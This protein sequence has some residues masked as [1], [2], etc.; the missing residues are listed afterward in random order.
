MRWPSES[1]LT[2]TVQST[3]TVA[4]GD[5]FFFSPASGFLTLPAPAPPAAAVLVAVVLPPPAPPRLRRAFRGL[6]LPREDLATAEEL[7]VV[8]LL[9]KPGPCMV[10]VPVSAVLRTHI[11]SMFEK[12][13]GQ[14][15]YYISG[16]FE[17]CSSRGRAHGPVQSR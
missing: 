14:W 3:S 5:F 2:F 13:G 9:F 17:K 1:S 12:A 15:R 11:A 6:C 10:G 7:L 4:P 16:V 8:L